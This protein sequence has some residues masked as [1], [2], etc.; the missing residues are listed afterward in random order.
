MPKLLLGPSTTFQLKS[1]I[2]PICGVKRTSMPPPNWPIALVSEL[3]L[4]KSPLDSSKLVRSPPPKIPPPPPKTYG[5]KRV[6]G[7]DSAG[8]TCPGRHQ[9]HGCYAQ[10]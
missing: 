3:S 6:Q 4:G 10:Y 7:L 1:L 2:Q 9:R 8:S 5:A